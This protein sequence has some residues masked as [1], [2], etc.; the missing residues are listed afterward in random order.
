[1]TQ[2]LTTFLM[3]NNFDPGEIWL[4]ICTFT[5]IKVNSTI[6][7]TYFRHEMNNTNWTPATCEQSV[8]QI[9]MVCKS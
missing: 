1:M 3:H 2:E 4:I 6:C 5:A 8:F 9:K 7:S